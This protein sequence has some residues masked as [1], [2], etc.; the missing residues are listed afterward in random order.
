MQGE[1][2]NFA[3]MLAAQWI[4]DNFPDDDYAPQRSFPPTH[5][6]ARER[7]R[8]P[9]RGPKYFIEEHTLEARGRCKAFLCR[10]GIRQGKDHPEARHGVLRQ[11]GQISG[12][13]GISN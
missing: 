10:G 11:Q 9:I 12:R 8:E 5:S 4:S 3:R 1:C 2:T 7:A 13:E 6:G